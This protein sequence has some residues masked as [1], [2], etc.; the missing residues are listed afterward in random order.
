MD[1]RGRLSLQLFKELRAL[2][3]YLVLV[4]CLKGLSWRQH[5]RSV[6]DFRAPIQAFPFGKGLGAEVQ[7]V[8]EEATATREKTRSSGSDNARY[9]YVFDRIH[10]VVD[11]EKGFIA[12]SLSVLLIRLAFGNPP[13]PR[14]KAF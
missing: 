11:K 12:K 6:G 1:S 8:A 3:F 13:S 10:E 7:P 9:D 2:I 4:F 14:G 5:L